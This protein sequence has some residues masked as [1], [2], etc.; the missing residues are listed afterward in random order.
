MNALL[1]V[2]AALILTVFAVSCLP[3]VWQVPNQ[4]TITAR[5]PLAGTVTVM[6]G[7]AALIA[8]LV[9]AFL[10]PRWS[11]PALLAAAVAAWLAP[12]YA[13]AAGIPA[14]LSA[15]ASGTALLAPAISAHVAVSLPDGRVSGK[16][17][18]RALLLA[19]LVS[20]A[21]ALL[22]VVAYDPFRD[23]A[24]WSSCRPNPLA[25]VSW[26]EAGTLATAGA[27]V[28][29]SVVIVALTRW[30]RPEPSAV[31]R[32]AVIA[33]GVL[34]AGLGLTAIGAVRAGGDPA[35]ALPAVSLVVSGTGIAV[36]GATV[37]AAAVGVSL[38]ACRL[39][40]LVAVP[41]DNR[42]EAH[43]VDALR[44]PGV[45]IAYRVGG[46]LVDSEG[47]PAELLP[48]PGDRDRR[49]TRVVRAAR[50][51]ALIEHR[52]DVDLTRELGPALRV[53]LENEALRVESHVAL[54]ELRASRTRI[55]AAS[56]ARRRVLERDL[57]DGVQQALIA[58]AWRLQ[59]AGRA[60]A[61][62]GEGDRAQA[63]GD[64]LREAR[65]ALE[66]LREVA[67][68]IHPA[69]LAN[70]GLGAALRSLALSA[71]IALSVEG[72]MPRLADAAESALH[73]F[74]AS[75]VSVLAHQ[76]VEGAHVALSAEG[77][78]ALVRLTP[79][80]EVAVRLDP[81]VADRLGALG[82]EV[83]ADAM[84]AWVPMDHPP[85]ARA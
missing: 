16:Q 64:A 38:R 30:R 66:E 51:I 17:R 40:A 33:S 76:G 27:L 83:G 14:G 20:L 23:I 7:V 22:R 61:A 13:T 60:A 71:P 79:S 57:H 46:R 35:R 24:C 72:T 34:A 47:G 81:I 74:V 5:A 84:R 37:L 69:V 55:V 80:R 62:R 73:V 65:A 15:V 18:R 67:H 41:E 9:S 19:Y 4:Y 59:T 12:A 25:V 42:I 50:E 70:E 11:S 49:H 75:A 31:S 6:A 56:D 36:A 82:G 8:G 29:G 32:L 78:R 28:T 10:Q 39:R 3:L 48:V 45:R 77:G 21:F 43:L 58:L 26:P 52:G 44:D 2:L 68:G 1:R 63:L 85:V 53:A 54:A